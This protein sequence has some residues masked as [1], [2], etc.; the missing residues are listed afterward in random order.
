MAV[1]TVWTPNSCRP[2][3]L[4]TPNGDRVIPSDPAPAAVPVGPVDPVAP[5][6]A[7][8][9]IAFLLERRLAD[10]Y[11]IKAY[12]GA[13]ATLLTVDPEEVRTR[14]EAGTLRDLPGI[15]SKTA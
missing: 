1:H 14:A 4:P 11:R 8:R 3:C 13:A 5:V 2:D 10:S 6:S 7:L 12:R 15:G 9:R